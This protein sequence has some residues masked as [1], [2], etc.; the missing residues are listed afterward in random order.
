VLRS[1]AK[2]NVITDTASGSCFV[3]AFEASKKME[4]ELDSLSYQEDMVSL[5]NKKLEW[6]IKQGEENEE[7]LSSGPWFRK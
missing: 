7:D 3:S 2:R 6:L 1:S 5:E 4:R